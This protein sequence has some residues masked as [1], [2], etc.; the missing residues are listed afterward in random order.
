MKRKMPIVELRP[1]AFSTG[2]SASAAKHASAENGALE[3]HQNLM[4]R[5]ELI[6]CLRDV[7]H[8]W[9][10]PRISY[11]EI[12]ELE[13]QN[14]IQRN[15]TSVC[16][17]RLTEEGA[18]VKNWRPPRPH[19]NATLTGGRL[20]A[21][22]SEAEETWE[23]EAEPRM[24]II[25]NSI[26][27]GLALAAGVTSLNARDTN[28]TYQGRVRGGGSDFTGTGQFKFALVTSQTQAH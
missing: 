20:P 1:F 26:L 13:R 16:A 19:E 12:E 3:E 17:I 4:T 23:N 22:L 14:L 21:K 18:L 9:S 5:G 2:A 15:T 7:H 6:F 28:V 27:M 11:H 24:K 8:Y 25:F 10:T